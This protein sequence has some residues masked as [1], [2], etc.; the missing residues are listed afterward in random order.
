MVFLLPISIYDPKGSGVY[1]ARDD[2]VSNDLTDDIYPLLF[3]YDIRG[4]CDLESNILP[5]A[6][7]AF[8]CPNFSFYPK[9]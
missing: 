1:G 7:Q 4:V 5:V 3:L 6:D 8:L 9:A 2:F